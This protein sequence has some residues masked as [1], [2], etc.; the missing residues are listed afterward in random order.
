M[1]SLKYKFKFNKIKIKSKNRLKNWKSNLSDHLEVCLIL[2]NI[3]LTKRAYHLRM[4]YT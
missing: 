3:Y 1:F 2:T 4:K